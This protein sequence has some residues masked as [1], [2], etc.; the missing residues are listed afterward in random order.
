MVEEPGEE[1]KLYR[2]DT[3]ELIAKGPFV[4]DPFVSNENQEH[5]TIHKTTAATFDSNKNSEKSAEKT[6]NNDF[7]NENKNNKNNNTPQKETEDEDKN[8]SSKQLYNDIKEVAENNNCCLKRPPSQ[9]V[10]SEKVSKNELQPETTTTTTTT[11]TITTTTTTAAVK[12]QPV[13]QSEQ[14]PSITKKLSRKELKESLKIPR[15]RSSSI[16][17]TNRR[18]KYQVINYI[19]SL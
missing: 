6:K 5:P 8:E 2:Q 12:D 13:P 17:S 3:G 18:F 14:L 10:E 15:Y 9:V 19:L 1:P 11:T 7:N 16:R 4:F